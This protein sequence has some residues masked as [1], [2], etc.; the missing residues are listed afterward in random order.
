LRLAACIASSVIVFAS[1]A[2]P[3]DATSQRVLRVTIAGDRA[4]VDALGASLREA[5]R[6]SDVTPELHAAERLDLGDTS[7][8]EVPTPG[9]LATAWVDLRGTHATVVVVDDAGHVV[10]RRFVPAG[11]STEITA[12]SVVEILAASAEDI[13]AH[14]SSVTVAAPA[15]ASVSPVIAPVETRRVV[16]TLP[17]SPRSRVALEGAVFL[18]TDSFADAAPIVV[19]GGTALAV[20]LG[21]GAFR[22]ALRVFVGTA[23]P[24]HV[25][26]PLVALDISTLTVR[27]GPM[28]RLFGGRTWLVELGVQA[29]ADVLWVSPH[30]TGLPSD[31]LNPSTVDASAVIGPIA[32][33]RVAVGARVDFSLT[34]AAD[35]DL[36]PRRYVIDDGPNVDV[37][38]QPWVV[39]PMLLLGFDF[40]LAGPALYA[41]RGAP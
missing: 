31:R 30:S 20:T 40:T 34:V 28:V 14:A 13:V 2:R 25:D 26:G 23:I 32:S 3:D 22:P 6:S 19:G 36:A 1:V 41:S 5:L 12:Q 27:A 39:R 11:A 16:P 10:V 7:L 33:A 4:T 38:F 15:S 18:T 24:F 21:H 29:G 17:A 9:V 37:L 35:C 8:L